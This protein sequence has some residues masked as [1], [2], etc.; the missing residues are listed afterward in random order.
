MRDGIPFSD[1]GTGVPR[2]NRGVPLGQHP[3]LTSA[4]AELAKA[5]GL[6]P[7]KAGVDTR[8]GDTHEAALVRM[9][10]ERLANA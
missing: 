5:L 4:L 6:S 9:A 8:V 3:S 7:E 10:V 1:D 2:D